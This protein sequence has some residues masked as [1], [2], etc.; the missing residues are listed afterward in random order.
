MWLYV[1]SCSWHFLNGPAGGSVGEEQFSSF[2][3]PCLPAKQK[4][5]GLSNVP[6]LP[7]HKNGISKVVLSKWVLR[8]GEYHKKGAKNNFVYRCDYAVFWSSNILLF[9]F[10]FFVISRNS[11]GFISLCPNFHDMALGRP[12]HGLQTFLDVGP[13][14][15][16]QQS[17]GKPHGFCYWWH[18]CILMNTWRGVSV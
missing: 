5:C 12:A 7:W 9:F 14:C 3:S 18:T 1:H 11:S 4:E 13:L 10:F 15:H 2:P 16:F 8:H 6:S 17:A